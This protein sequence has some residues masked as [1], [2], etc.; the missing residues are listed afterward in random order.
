MTIPSLNENGVL[1][2]GIHTCTVE[3]IRARFGSFQSSEQRPRLMRRLEAFLAEV[4][5]SNIVRAVIV[6]GSFVTGK[7]AP[8]DIDLLL[9]LAA[10]HDFHVDLSPTQYRVVDSRRV[11]RTYGLDIVVVEDASADYA[12]LVHLFHRVRLQPHLTKGILRVEL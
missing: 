6:N 10:G 11:R 4:R 9:V 5:A 3:E 7:P 2:E 8:N 12:A 1:P